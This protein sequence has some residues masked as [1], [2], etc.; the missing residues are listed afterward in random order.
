M[1]FISLVRFQEGHDAVIPPLS[2]AQK[3]A[4]EVLKD[5]CKRESLY[6]VLDPGNI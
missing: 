6:I 4:I 3:H 1:N 5:T 2:K